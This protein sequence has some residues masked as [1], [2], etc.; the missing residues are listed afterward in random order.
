MKNWMNKAK[1]TLNSS[2]QMRVA[3]WMVNILFIFFSWFVIEIYNFRSL[4][5]IKNFILK[6][7][8]AFVMGIGLTLIIYAF[9]LFISRRTWVAA[10]ILGGVY[11]IAGIVNYIKVDL[12]GDPFVPMDFS[13]TGNMGELLSFVNV[14]MP[15]W[16]YLMPVFMVLYIGLII[17]WDKKLPKGK[18]SIVCRIVGVVILPIILVTFLLPKNVEKNFEKFGMNFADTGLQSSNYRA[19]GFLGGFYLNIA[20]MQVAP[21][22]GYAKDAVNEILK[23][24][25]ETDSEKDPDI[26][27]FLCESYWDVRKLEGVTFSTDPLYFYDEL[28]KRENAYGGT[29]Y[30]TALGGG[31]V[32][33]EFDILTG[34]TTDYLPAGAS[35]YLYPSSKVPSYVSTYKDNGYKT[36]A[37]HPYDKSFYNRNKAYPYIGFDE[38]Y[39]QEELIELLGNVTYERGYFSD[40]SFVDAIIS[41][42]NKNEKEETFLFALSM[43][44][45][46]TYYPLEEYDIEVTCP[47]MEEE[48]LGTVNTY[49][50]GVYHS[51]KALEKLINYI[52]NREKETI[53]I[54]FGDHLPTL[55]GNYAAYR[56]TGYFKDEEYGHEQRKSMYGTPYVVYGNYDLEDGVFQKGGKNE[57][58]TYYL[59]SAAALSGGLDR[60][61]Y[62]NWLLDQHKEIPYYNVRLLMEETD[63][64]TNLKN[65]HKLITYDRLIGKRYSEK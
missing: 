34:L 5:L 57:I 30:S 1:N 2:P 37:L 26:I 17:L 45:H 18:V 10:L 42:L 44:N 25:P 61:P 31:T 60:S 27:V 8:M 16:G 32:R 22:E 4:D 58:S 12:N 43:E 9:F 64:I 46:Q 13:M 52:D 7:P 38:F 65:A 20:T 39:G 23:D 63:K 11:Q 29:I 15:W 24:Y 47:S 6:R 35:P 40:D 19:N 21:P 51:S 53:L 62:M 59:L 56:A 33:T 36:I 50:Q 54:F 14:I 55:G 41:Q 49:A 48:L 3:G 28:C